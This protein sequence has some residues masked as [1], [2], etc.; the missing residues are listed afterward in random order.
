MSNDG[1]RIIRCGVVGSNANGSPDVFYVKV[2]CTE[3]QYENGDHYKVASTH[4]EE[5]HS[6][7]P[8]I[9]IDENDDGKAVIDLMD[10]NTIPDSEA[11]LVP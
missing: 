2:S 8:S 1:R 4:V 10:W 7:E 3:E 9:T 5:E 6:F 11:V